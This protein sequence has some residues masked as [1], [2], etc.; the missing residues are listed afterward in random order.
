ME[1][2]YAVDKERQ[3]KNRIELARRVADVRLDKEKIAREKAKSA[4]VVTGLKPAQFTSNPAKPAAGRLPPINVLSEFQKAILAKNGRVAENISRQI[5]AGVSVEKSLDAAYAK[6][7]ASFAKL[8]A[9]ILSVVGSPQLAEV[10]YNA[11]VVTFSPQRIAAL[12]DMFGSWVPALSGVKTADDILELLSRLRNALINRDVAEFVGADAAP[13]ELDF[14][15][16][17]VAPEVVADAEEEAGDVGEEEEFH[18]VREAP[19]EVPEEAPGEVPEE[20]APPLLARVSETLRTLVDRIAERVRNHENPDIDLGR[21]A[22]FFR[23]LRRARDVGAEEEL[24]EEDL[25]AQ[26]RQENMP[27]LI[28]QEVA[29]MEDEREIARLE[30]EALNRMENRVPPVAPDR[31]ALEEAI[32][33]LQ[34]R[35]DNVEPEAPVIPPAAPQA[36][37]PIRDEDYDRLEE[38]LARLQARARADNV[39]PPEGPIGRAT[40]LEEKEPEGDEEK[41]IESE[42]SKAFARLDKVQSDFEAKGDY[43]SANEIASRINEVLNDSS[44][45]R[46]IEIYTRHGIPQNTTNEIHRLVRDTQNAIRLRD[47][48]KLAAVMDLTQLIRETIKENYGEVGET[49]VANFDEELKGQY[50]ELAR[51]VSVFSAAEG[52]LN[53][54]DAQQAAWEREIGAIRAK[55]R[56]GAVKDAREAVRLLQNALRSGN[57]DNMRAYDTKVAEG[58]DKLTVEFGKEVATGIMNELVGLAQDSAMKGREKKPRTLVQIFSN[59]SKGAGIKKSGK[60]PGVPKVFPLNASKSARKSLAAGMRKAGNDN[61]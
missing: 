2:K 40:N 45:D 24:G 28:G 59:P 53:S 36:A 9:K 32:A 23:R 6:A 58:I 31:G 54:I 13:A 51:T 16:P 46:R 15:R 25:P 52:E 11:I 43:G 44:P 1:H 5:T 26:L 57:F 41:V 12:S 50:D 21:L 56:A 7:D 4:T 49:A 48:N 27:R 17:D 14:D 29:R 37:A 10:I 38:A 42:E 22:D 34:A 33:R 39:G 3:V 55:A 47:D 18:D 8:K 60:G 35:A 20:E 30:D 19:R 61:C